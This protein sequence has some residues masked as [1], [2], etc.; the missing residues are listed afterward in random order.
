MIFSKDNTLADV[1]KF[2]FRTA[3]VF[4]K[5]SLD[6]CCNGNR[7]L[8]L[9][10]NEINI[11]PENLLQEISSVISV[12]DSSDNPENWDLIKLINH[13]LEVHHSYIRNM[14]PVINNHSQK[15]KEAHGINHPELIEI[16][17]I[18]EQLCYE[19]DSHMHKE[20][21]ML[22]PAI[23]QM[24][25]TQD[26]SNSKYLS[27]FGTINNPIS[28]MEK[29]HSAAGIDLYKIRELSNNYLPPDDAC[30]TYQVFFKELNEFEEDLHKHIHLENN[31]LF[32]KA[33][34]LETKKFL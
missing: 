5:Y 7:T 22:F 14:I 2:D 23:I 27:P 16:S 12:K 4:E 18:F 9:A 19:L 32:P 25:E 10:C 33:I 1:V 20:E 34:A 15:V 6:F 30:N 24:V 8:E 21:M 28:V 26:E 17:E 11:T 29:E 31:I 13:I 3:R